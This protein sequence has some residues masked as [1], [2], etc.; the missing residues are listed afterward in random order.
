MRVTAIVFALMLSMSGAAFAQ[1]WDLYVNTEDGFKVDFPGQPKVADTSWTSEFGYI[2]PAR[3]YSAD[4]GSSHYSMTV[5]DY[6]QI[7]RLG[8]ERSEKCPVGAETCQGQTAGGLR[9]IIGPSYAVHDSRGALVYAS[10]KFIQRNAKVTDYLW[11]WEDLVEGYEIHLTNNADQSRTLAYV[12]MHEN[13]LYI[14]EGT[15]PKGYPEPG[16]FYQSLGWVDKNGNGIRYQAIYINEVHGLR[17]A[18]PPPLAGGGGF[19]AAPAGQ[20]P[21]GGGAGAAPGR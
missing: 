10:F 3:V 7:E 8:M 21:A 15:V 18:P 9:H 19:G 2:L 11:N 5:V 17:I 13:K 14:L 4:M 12:A 1:E 6:T 20:A 16:L